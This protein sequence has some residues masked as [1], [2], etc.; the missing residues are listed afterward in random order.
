MSNWHGTALSNFFRVKDLA[1]FKS[2]VEKELPGVEVRE[3]AA[4]GPNDGR[5]CV[6]ASRDSDNGGWPT[7]IVDPDD[8]EDE[9]E[10]D[11]PRSIS[12][13]LV[14][15]EIVV[16]M[17]SGADR[18]KYVTGDSVA[19]DHTG[20]CVSVSLNDVYKKARRKFGKN[21]GPILY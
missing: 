21:P 9:V 12:Q 10:V 8:H 20:K 4:T 18:L 14:E 2:M 17:Q 19:F 3:G 11:M 7:W 13:H 6:V 1:G 15:G 5:V 16:L